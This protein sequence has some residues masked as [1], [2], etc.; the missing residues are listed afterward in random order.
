MA[1]VDLAA[2]REILPHKSIDMTLR[3]AHLSGDHNQAAVDAF[4]NALAGGAEKDAETA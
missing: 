1:G 4:Q 3:Y 2:V